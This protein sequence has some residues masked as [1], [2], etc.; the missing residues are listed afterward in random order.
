MGYHTIFER[1]RHGPGEHGKDIVAILEYDSE[2]TV[3]VFQLKVDDVS[4]TRF[5]TEI[6]GELN[7]MFEVPIVHPMLQGTENKNYVLISTGDFSRDAAIEFQGYNENNLRIGNPEIELW[8]ISK[9]SS[10]FYQHIESFSIVSNKNKDDLSR[11]WLEIKEN[12][13]DRNKWLTFINTQLNT[14]NSSYKERI[15]LTS[16]F[17]VFFTSECVIIK[18][19]I[20][21]LDIIKISLLKIWS[22]VYN[23]KA[24]IKY[25]DDIHDEYVALLNLYVESILE[26]LDKKNGLY[27][28]EYGA[29]EA[30][31]YPMR[32]FTILGSLSYLITYYNNIGRTEHVE[33]LTKYIELVI[34]NNTGVLTPPAD[35]LSKDIAYALR[36]LLKFGSNNVAINWLK[37]ILHN[38]NQRYLLNNWW[39]CESK[40]P[41]D[42][43]ERA[44]HFEGLDEKDEPA[45]YL[46]PIL[47]K[48]CSKLDLK[49]TYD[50]Y[51]VA[52]QDFRFFECYPGEDI[53]EFEKAIYHGDFSKGIY[54]EKKFPASFEEFKTQVDTYVNAEYFVL[55]INR[56]HILH[57]IS[58][59]YGEF[60]FPEIYMDF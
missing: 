34:I 42:I 6:R 12:K 33:D 21:A 35:Y 53:R 55:K 41:E 31:L 3:T 60:I 37:N 40:N 1:T 24:I 59:V 52:F 39:P 58:D 22:I 10:L 27:N 19:Y 49:S 15:I 45:T 23:N 29:I 28:D 26:V 20:D 25:F 4:L 5:R 48:F 9:L 56:S 47:F 13:Y 54:V 16:L 30:I 17:T 57:L 44:F 8:N 11:I 36:S 51:R 32:T 2:T 38:L 18:N 46:I 7:P 43:I 50:Q 14:I